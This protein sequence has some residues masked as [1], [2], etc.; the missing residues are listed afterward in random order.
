MSN[1]ARNKRIFTEFTDL[2]GLGVV[3]IP[4]TENRIAKFSL[5]GLTSSSLFDN[6]STITL[7]SGKQVTSESGVAVLDF[8]T[9]GS[10]IWSLD[11]DSNS[12]GKAWVYGDANSA[13][14]GYSN[15]SLVSVDNSQVALSSTDGVTISSFAIT[16]SGQL[17]LSLTNGVKGISMDCDLDSLITGNASHTQLELLNNSAGNKT[18]GNT[19]K[20]ASSLGSQNSTLASGVINSVI[21]GGTGLYG[22]TNNTAYVNQIG[23]ANG[24]TNETL[25]AFTA[26]TGNRTITFEN[27]S[28]RVLTGNAVTTEVVISDTTISIV[29]NG[30]S[31]KLLARA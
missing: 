13:Q 26:P 29:Y 25:L 24:A 3:G 27:A 8:G 2:S 1:I 28:G 7:D 19:T 17:G 15:I 4:G 11:A 23:Y 30:I 10:E 31:Y 18:T 6:G 21:L 20:Y 22:K 16:K 14:L 5:I 12:Y 9:T